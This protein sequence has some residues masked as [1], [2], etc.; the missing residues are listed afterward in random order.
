MKKENHLLKTNDFAKVYEK[1][2]KI[3]SACMSVYYSKNE[4]G[5]LRVGLSVS[6]KVGKAHT[7]VR[8]RRLIR[9][10]MDRYNSYSGSYDIIIVARVGF[11]KHN[12]L[13]LYEELKPILNRFLKEN[14]DEKKN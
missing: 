9:A 13:E 7:R 4:L 5:Y 14:L 1:R 3:Q 11:E 2:H 6:K 10:L 8:I 12:F